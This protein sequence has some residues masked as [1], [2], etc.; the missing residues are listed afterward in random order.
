M[1]NIL[2]RHRVE[3]QYL[4]AHH[5]SPVTCRL[6]ALKLGQRFGSA[7]SNAFERK[8]R[9]PCDK[10]KVRSSGVKK[11]KPS[12]RGLKSRSK[13]PFSFKRRVRMSLMKNSQSAGDHS[14]PSRTRPI[15]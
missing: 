14:T 8:M 1:V 11:E 7:P 4:L 5:R 2:R 3:W 10:K 9:A 6:V 15:R 12:G 13:R